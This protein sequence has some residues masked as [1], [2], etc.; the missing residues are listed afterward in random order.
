MAEEMGFS[1]PSVSRAL[2]KLRDDDLILTNRDGY[3]A[4]TE[5]GRAIA[6]KV[7]RKHQLLTDFIMRLG[8]SEEIAEKDA[9]RIE[10]VI[11]D[12]TFDAMVRHAEKHS[13]DKDK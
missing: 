12:E 9:C 3:I 8:V 13:S 6:E 7:Y 11:S 1:K 5:S 4:F 2:T 10:H